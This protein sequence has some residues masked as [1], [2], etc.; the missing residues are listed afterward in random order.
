M[1]LG[2]AMATPEKL[3][4]MK[5]DED[6][7]AGCRMQFAMKAQA[8]GGAAHEEGIFPLA[9]F[10]PPQD[11]TG[12]AQDQHRHAQPADERAPVAAHQEI[13]VQLMRESE[14]RRQLR[15]AGAQHGARNRIDEDLGCGLLPGRAGLP[16]FGGALRAR[17]PALGCSHADR[18]RF[19]RFARQRDLHRATP[20]RAARR[21]DDPVQRQHLALGGRVRHRRQDFGDGIVIDQ[22]AARQ[23]QQCQQQTQHKTDPHMDLEQKLAKRGK[24]HGILMRPPSGGPDC[25]KV[26]SGGRFR[27][28]RRLACAIPEWPCPSRTASVRALSSRTM[29]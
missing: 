10:G 18:N 12:A 17:A 9:A 21:L 11:Q 6:P 22:D 16:P 27:H 26:R 25:G 1:A 7:D 5:T 20:R 8:L 2:K 23:T 13:A 3:T 4:T 15:L 14:N 29:L 28:C 24:A 19:A